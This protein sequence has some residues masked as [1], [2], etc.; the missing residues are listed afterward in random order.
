MVDI[1]TPWKLANSKN[2]AVCL[3]VSES[4]FTGRPLGDLPPRF[5]D[6]Q[7]LSGH[8]HVDDP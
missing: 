5:Q 8:L 2:Q 1:F 4:R 6:S 3:F 7:L